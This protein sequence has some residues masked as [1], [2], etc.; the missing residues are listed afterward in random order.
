[1][2]SYTDSLYMFIYNIDVN[3]MIGSLFINILVKVH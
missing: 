3:F 1:M 2:K